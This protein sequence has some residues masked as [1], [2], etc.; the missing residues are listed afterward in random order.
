M[1][2]PARGRSTNALPRQ[3]GIEDLVDFQG[4]NA[5]SALVEAEEVP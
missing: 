5:I 1:R 2:H 3:R 4:L